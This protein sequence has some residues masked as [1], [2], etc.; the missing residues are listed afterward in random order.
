MPQFNP[1]WQTVERCVPRSFK[2]IAVEPS[3]AVDMTAA[4]QHLG[5]E[6]STSFQ[7]PHLVPHAQAVAQA[8]PC[9]KLDAAGSARG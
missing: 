7:S 8:G 4:D 2:A 1:V 5:P 3:K 6:L 9:I